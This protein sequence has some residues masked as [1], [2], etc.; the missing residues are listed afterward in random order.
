MGCGSTRCSEDSVRCSGHRWGQN[1]SWDEWGLHGGSAPEGSQQGLREWWDAEMS[2]RGASQVLCGNRFISGVKGRFSRHKSRV[3]RRASGTRRS[4]RRYIEFFPQLSNR[5]D[6]VLNSTELR[7][8]NLTPKSWFIC[9]NKCYLG[10]SF[11]FCATTVVARSA[12]RRTVY[13]TGGRTVR[14]QSGEVVDRMTTG[15]EDSGRW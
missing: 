12:E 6:F 15:W 4:P 11:L 5:V 10:V 3:G 1:Y 9:T 13:R 7:A 8:W 2:T 14:W